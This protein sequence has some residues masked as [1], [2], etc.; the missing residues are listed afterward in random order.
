MRRRLL[1]VI[2]PLVGLLTLVSCTG[3]SIGKIQE[4]Y[5][6]PA[7]SATIASYAATLT[8]AV[9]PTSTPLPRVA[10]VSF[11]DR[12][13]TALK[14]SDG[15]LLKQI[16]VPSECGLFTLDYQPNG[17]VTLKTC[18]DR[19]VT[20]P[21]SGSTRADWQVWQD[22]A[23]G[24]CGQFTPEHYGKGVAFKTC[25]GKYL[26]A[27]DDSWPPPLQWSVVAETDKVDKWEVFT[28]EYQP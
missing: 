19:F 1:A 21:R 3:S 2:V 17:K 15:W 20:A 7:V 6:A 16:G 14:E 11:H 9:T 10:L 4:T 27:G 22:S 5:V 8:A 12:Y 26:T 24:D 18:N 13:V 28:M 23:A 25:A